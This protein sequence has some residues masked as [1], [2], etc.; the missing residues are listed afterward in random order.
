MP[1][2]FHAGSLSDRQR[3]DSQAH[4]NKNSA[5]GEDAVSQETAG[6][7]TLHRKL[8]AGGMGRVFEAEDPVAR[9]GLR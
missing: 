3:V 2:S 6:R 8:P 9:A 4:D 5:Q 1:P 7:F